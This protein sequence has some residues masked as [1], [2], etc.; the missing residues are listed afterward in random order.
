M[1]DEWCSEVEAVKLLAVEDIPDINIAVFAKHLNLAYEKG[2]QISSGQAA[3]KLDLM[4]ADLERVKAERDRMADALKIVKVRIHFVGMPSEAFLANGRPDWST[5]IKAIESALS[6]ESC[7]AA[8][9][10]EG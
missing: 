10:G 3:S 5:E 6:S 7:R 8:E 1:S 9:G 2:K 4:A